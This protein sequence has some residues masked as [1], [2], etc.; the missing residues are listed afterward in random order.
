MEFIYLADHLEFLPTLAEWHHG[1][2]GYIRP[3]DTAEAREKR[4]RAECGHA[5]IPTTIIA[6]DKGELLGSVMLLEEDMDTHKQLSPW[7]ASLFVASQRRR[8]GIGAALVQRAIEEAKSS[9]WSGS[10][11]TRRAKND[12]TAGLAGPCWS[13]Q[14][15]RANQRLSWLSTF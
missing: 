4:L 6:V 9:A 8:Q 2:W 1:E 15:T 12:S 14:S 5:E 13:E 7:L 10:I 11:S 3:H